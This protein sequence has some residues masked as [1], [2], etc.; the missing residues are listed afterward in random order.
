MTNKTKY[1]DFCWCLK[2]RKE[3]F[4]KYSERSALS[5]TR[6]EYFTSDLQNEEARTDKCVSEVFYIP[7]Q[8]FMRT[9]H[10]SD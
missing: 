7:W 10:D 2:N 8:F 9:E 1:K 3:F 6:R 5:V 4:Y